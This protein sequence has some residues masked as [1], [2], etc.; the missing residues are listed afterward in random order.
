MS[1]KPLTVLLVVNSLA[2]NGRTKPEKLTTNKERG[3]SS[4]QHRNCHRLGRV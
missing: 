1:V 2:S 3:D 4:V